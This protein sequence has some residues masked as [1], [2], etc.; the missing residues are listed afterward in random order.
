MGG[1]VVGGRVV[2]GRVVG[3]NV[4]G[5]RV[6]GG[7]VVGGRVVGGNV[8]GGKVVRGVC[9]AALVDVAQ[10]GPNGLNSQRDGTVSTTQGQ[11]FRAL[12]S[13]LSPKAQQ[14]AELAKATQA[15]HHNSKK[16]PPQE[17]LQRWFCQTVVTGPLASCLPQR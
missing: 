14:H 7:R 6:V 2:G 11:N 5:G 13:M 15:T 8:V 17:D 4:V 10:G 9:P 16:F 3:G 12:P 1:N